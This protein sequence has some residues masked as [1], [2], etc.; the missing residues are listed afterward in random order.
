MTPKVP[1]VFVLV[2]AAVA[3]PSKG[4]SGRAAG[5]FQVRPVRGNVLIA[6]GALKTPAKSG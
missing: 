4:D 2:R 5:T 1:N 3:G 6:A